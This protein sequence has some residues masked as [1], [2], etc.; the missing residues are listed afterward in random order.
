MAEEPKLRIRG[1]LYT[2]PTSSKLGDAALIE[3]LT[4]L[5][6]KDWR[7]RYVDSIIA[8]IESGDEPDEAVNAV[9]EDSA[10]T[11]G[12]VAIAVSR[13]NPRWSRSQIVEFVSDLDFDEVE[14]EGG[15]ASPP[16]EEP[17][18]DEAI[19]KNGIEPAETSSS[20]S[21]SASKTSTTPPTSGP[22]TSPTSPEESL[23]TP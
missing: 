7:K 22:S 18:T 23:P 20:D 14:I 9:E 5:K 21:D 1:K 12:I 3:Q 2:Y 8:A 6:H 17:T 16:S 11:I 19:S 15:D 4:G 10:V 13:G